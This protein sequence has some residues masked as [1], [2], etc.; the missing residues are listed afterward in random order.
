MI[1]KDFGNHITVFISRFSLSNFGLGFD[2]YKMYNWDNGE[3]TASVTQLSFLFF[4]VTI[5]FWKD[6]IAQWTSKTS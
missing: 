3:H 4:N 1:E 5:T 6:G 2:Y